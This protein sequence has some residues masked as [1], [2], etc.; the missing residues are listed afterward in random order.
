VCVR[1]WGRVGPLYQIRGFEE[2]SLVLL[3]CWWPGSPQRDVYLPPWC[4]QASV[5]G[6]LTPHT[7]HALG[8]PCKASY[9]VDPL[10]V[11]INP[12]HIDGG[13]VLSVSA[14]FVSCIGLQARDNRAHTVGV[15]V[16]GLGEG[17]LYRHYQELPG[18]DRL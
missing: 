3:K 6:A 16:E 11:S 15:K 18:S 7:A 17:I 14:G 13:P 12:L 10:N 5:H 9:R 1:I 4:R 2:R 8:L